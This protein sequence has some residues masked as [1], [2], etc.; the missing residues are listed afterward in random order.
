MRTL[1]I[2]SA[3]ALLMA[4]SGELAVAAPAAFGGFRAHRPG[5]A[6]WRR[7][8]CGHPNGTADIPTR[9]GPQVSL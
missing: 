6:T 1:L 9:W 3:A 8:Q 7:T 5:A 4:L 2:A